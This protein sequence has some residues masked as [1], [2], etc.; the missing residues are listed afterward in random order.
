MS[1]CVSLR[2]AGSVEHT[3]I[4]VTGR[5]VRFET[6]LHRGRVDLAALAKRIQDVCTALGKNGFTV[7]NVYN[8]DVLNTEEHRQ[9]LAH[10]RAAL[11]GRQN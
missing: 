5:D 11:S 9:L 8:L 6:H 10:L 4:G 3:E 1:L 2:R 7:I